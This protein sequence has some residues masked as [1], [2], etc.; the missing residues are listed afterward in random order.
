MILYNPTVSGSLLV[1]GSLTTT[2]TITSQ[3]LV[4]QTITS[5]IEFNTGSTRNGSLSTNTHEFTG[6]VSITGSGTATKLIVASDANAGTIDFGTGIYKGIMDYSAGS[7]LWRLNN[8]SA[9]AGSTLYYQFQGDGTASMSILKNGN[10]GIGTNSPSTLLHLS[11]SYNGGGTGMLHITS[12]GTEGG[13]ITFEKTSGTA[14][15]YKLGNSGTS[16]FVYN[17][18]GASQPFTILN[19]GR[20]GIG[21]SS[22]ETTLDVNGTTRITG[23][24]R[25]YMNNSVM[26]GMVLQH[27]DLANGDG[28]NT[29]ETDAKATNGNAKKRASGASSN[30]FF[31]GPY[32]T[33]PAGNYVAGFRMKVTSNA[34]SS[35]I[36][37]IDVSNVT[38]T[39][40][41]GALAPNNFTSSDAY[42]YFKIYF[43]VANPSAQIEFRGLS[44]VSGITDIFLD[45]ILIMPN[46]MV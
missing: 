18:T 9:G 14:Q 16:L 24:G 36:V 28:S 21:I 43:T 41:A 35:R 38:A 37:S 39:S 2:G 20:V 32:A 10:V 11:S 25:F 22:P 6:S 45:H 1:T 19:N 46:L 13:T 26:L 7:G 42:Q 29:T 17:E 44:F 40:G 15:K 4:V 33:L 27:G 8:Q 5:S 3:T 23:G 34:S 30:T 12:N 31:Y